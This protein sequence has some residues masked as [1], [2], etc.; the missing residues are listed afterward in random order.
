MTISRLTSKDNPL[1]KKIRSVASL[2]R[3]SPRDLV[4]AE[5]VRVL[6]EVCRSACIIET[7]VFSESFGSLSRER[8]LLEALSRKKVP[9]FQVPDRIFASLSDVRTPQGAIALVHVPPISLDEA[10]P[11]TVPLIVYACGIQDPGNLGT[12]LRAAA[13]AGATMVCTSKSSVSA[14]NPKAVR[15]SA[16]AFFHI[17]V[18]ENT[19]AGDFRDYCRRRSISIFRTDPHSGVSYDRQD[20]RS[21]CAILLGNE[22]AGVAEREFSS[23]PA[24]RIPMAKGVESLNVAM[25]G[26]LILFEAFRQRSNP[27]EPA[28]LPD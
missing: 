13:A 20:L 27:K 21:P 4:L 22:G 28:R 24:I 16:G 23:F 10:A 3:R 7:A 9:L 8:R 15:S 19:D 5:G 12:L 6:E 25:A 18:V 11:G 26:T 1:L 17:P 2:A 14:R